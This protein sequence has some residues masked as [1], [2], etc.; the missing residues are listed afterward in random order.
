MILPEHI[1]HVPTRT[2]TGTALDLSTAALSAGPEIHQAYQQALFA[3]PQHLLS[4]GYLP[5]GLPSLRESI[6]RHYCER[7]LPTQPDEVMVVN[8]AVSGLALILRLLTGR[9]IA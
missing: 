2:V 4:S 9:T 5:Q 7:G 1:R 8:G 3:I 6:A